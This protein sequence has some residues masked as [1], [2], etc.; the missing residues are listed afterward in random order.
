MYVVNFIRCLC[1]LVTWPIPARHTGW[2]APQP[3]HSQASPTAAHAHVYITIF[4]A[5]THHHVIL[6]N[7]D[8][9]ASNITQMHV[10][11]D[12]MCQLRCHASKQPEQ[13]NVNSKHNIDSR[14][15]KRYFEE[16]FMKYWVSN[17]SPLHS[18]LPYRRMFSIHEGPRLT[19]RHGISHGQRV[20]N[21]QLYCTF[22]LY[23]CNRIERRF[24]STF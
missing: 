22:D 19:Y 23:R 14:R 2:A 15:K 7:A 6:M 17:K 1:A 24:K 16:I 4:P 12:F 3:I 13:E 21:R 18:S 20:N 11:Q 10:R 8:S 9:Y 5:T